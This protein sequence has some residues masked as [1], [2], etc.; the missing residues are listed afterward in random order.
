MNSA[1]GCCFESGI[2][3]FV[4]SAAVRE[5]VPLVVG[6]RIEVEFLATQLLPIYIPQLE[7]WA[8]E[9]ADDYLLGNYSKADLI[10][11]RIHM[12]I[13]APNGEEILST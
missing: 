10:R 12:R 13:T 1:S 4:V 8:T 7:N 6:C 11:E 5:S 3:A 2:H 9:V